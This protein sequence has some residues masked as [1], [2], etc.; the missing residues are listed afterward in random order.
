MEHC[1]KNAFYVKNQTKIKWRNNAKWLVKILN[2]SFVSLFVRFVT[3][4]ILVFNCLLHY[5]LHL[6]SCITLF[7]LF[8]FDFFW[9]AAIH[10]T[11]KKYVLHYCNNNLWRRSGYDYVEYFCLFWTS[12]FINFSYFFRLFLLVLHSQINRMSHPIF[13]PMKYIVNMFQRVCSQLIRVQCIVYTLKRFC[14]LVKILQIGK[15]LQF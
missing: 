5:C 15:E 7:I 14:K 10:M 6:S 1:A 9:Y 8:L 12:M 11:L 2:V 13:C 4:K 3:F